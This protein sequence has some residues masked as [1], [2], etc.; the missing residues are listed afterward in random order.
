MARRAKKRRVASVR[1]QVRKPL[2]PAAQTHEDE[3]KYRR[4]REKQRLLRELP[5][6]N[7]R[8]T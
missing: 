1:N 5:N 7:G 8:S 6:G 3:R 4:P 2:P